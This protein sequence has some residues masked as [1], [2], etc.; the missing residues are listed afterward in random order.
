MDSIIQKKKECL[1]CHTTIGL[2]IHHI[3]PGPRRHISEEYGLKVWLCHEHHT[4]THGV[5]FDKTF[6]QELKELGQTVFV[7]KYGEPLFFA[8]FGKNYLQGD[9]DDYE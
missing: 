3:F 5:H 4:G 1:V 7:E 9:T 2:E 6:M 8:R